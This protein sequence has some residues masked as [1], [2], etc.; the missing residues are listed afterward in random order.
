M[1]ET[2]AAKASHELLSASVTIFANNLA[3]LPDG[4]TEEDRYELED[5]ILL[6]RDLFNAVR[7]AFQS[8]LVRVNRGAV[9]FDPKTQERYAVTLNMIGTIF[10][11]LESRAD[12]MNRACDLTVAHYNDLYIWRLELQ[13]LLKQQIVPVAPASSAFDEVD[14]SP[15][16]AAFFK[17][18]LGGTA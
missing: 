13:T 15:A 3:N 2:M 12:E 6:A 11:Q 9:G 7:S 10:G 18:F 17:K 4:M 1:E 14:L 5:Q 8:W 16:N